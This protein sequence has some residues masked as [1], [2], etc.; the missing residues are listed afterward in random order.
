[1]IHGLFTEQYELFERTSQ[2][3]RG[4]MGT[5][6]L[7]IGIVFNTPVRFSAAVSTTCGV[8]LGFIGA[9]DE[10]E[11]LFFGDDTARIGSREFGAL[12]TVSIS[13]AGTTGTVEI[14]SVDSGGQP[15]EFTRSKGILRGKSNFK[16]YSYVKL[17]SG[18]VIRTDGTITC[19]KSPEVKPGDLIAFNGV[20]YIVDQRVLANW[21]AGV[22][23]QELV[24]RRRGQEEL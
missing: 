24:V 15:I 14:R 1:M 11:W 16:K 23:H 7:H 12:S 5:A 9:E 13:P 21:I 20:E 22:S 3:Y 18:T 19:Q 2:V 8:S 4:P 10:E 6:G 17:P